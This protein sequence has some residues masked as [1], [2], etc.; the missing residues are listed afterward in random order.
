MLYV[1]LKS[2]LGFILTISLIIHHSNKISLKNDPFYILYPN[3][4]TDKIPNKS[5]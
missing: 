2:R 5:I 3:I 1:I 4:K